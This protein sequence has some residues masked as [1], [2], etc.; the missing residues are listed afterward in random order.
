MA[1]FHRHNRYPDLNHLALED[2]KRSNHKLGAGSF[3]SVEEVVVKGKRLAG[4]FYHESSLY[5]LGIG[6]DIGMRRLASECQLLSRIHHPNL[7]DFIGVFFSHNPIPA[8]VMEQMSLSL[9]MLLNHVK[10]VELDV[11]LH[12]L[13]EVAKGLVF[14]HSNTPPLVHRDLTS[15]N[16]LLSEDA[17]TVK[18]ADY[19]NVSIVDPEKV[20][21][22]LR[23]Q[24]VLSYMPPEATTAHPEFGPPLDIFSFG[25]LS[26]YTLLKKFPGNLLPK[27]CPGMSS[28]L[29]VRTELERRQ[30]YFD[31]LEDI[32]DA[33][34]PITEVVRRCLEDMPQMR[35][36]FVCMPFH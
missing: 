3:G 14:L 12:I 4:K 10:D 30:K 32:V 15:N 27:F 33:H 24:V 8:I 25:H 20:K 21:I 28:K 5:S 6:S 1:V 22:L 7:V 29:H 23:N 11:K 19:R 18:I 26:L 16:V 13:C 9:E 36:G 2:V 31:I 17:A 35:Y 34:S